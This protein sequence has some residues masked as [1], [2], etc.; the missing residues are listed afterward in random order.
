MPQWRPLAALKVGG[1]GIE[2]F[3][4]I[5]KSIVDLIIALVIILICIDGAFQLPKGKRKEK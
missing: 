2:R 5:P 4:G 3:T 1:L